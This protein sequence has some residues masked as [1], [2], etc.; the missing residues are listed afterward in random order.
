MAPGE[1]RSQQPDGGADPLTSVL[2]QEVGCDTGVLPTCAPTDSYP[3]PT[4]VKLRPLR[5]QRTMPDPCAGVP[6]NRWC[7]AGR[8]R[9]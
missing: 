9:R 4:K 3:Q 1:R 5:R 7:R 8:G 6:A 2:G